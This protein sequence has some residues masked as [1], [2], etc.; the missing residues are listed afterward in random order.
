MRGIELYDKE[1][2]WV[3]KLDGRRGAFPSPPSVST[4]A[5]LP[6]QPQ[7]PHLATQLQQS[8]SQQQQQSSSAAEVLGPAT[9]AFAAAAARSAAAQNAHASSAANDANA[10]HF[11]HANAI[12]T[13][14]GAAPSPAPMLPVTSSDGHKR[15]R[16]ILAPTNSKA[17]SFSSVGT[18]THDALEQVR[19]YYEEGERMERVLF[20][21]PW[22][23]VLQRI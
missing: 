19:V 6:L 14:R 15:H 21:A 13:A 5:S 23:Y 2:E 20:L 16:D 1:R 12:A 8:S 4:A 11:S 17:G 18:L 9:T 22:K 3:C 10:A 7:S